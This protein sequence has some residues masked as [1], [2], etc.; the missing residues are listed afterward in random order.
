MGGMDQERVWSEFKNGSKQAFESV[1]NYCI[2][3][4]YAYGLKLNSNKE[5]VK[6]CIQQVFVDIYERRQVLSNPQNIK[7]YVLKALKHQ[8]YKRQKKEKKKSNIDEFSELKFKT[9]YNFEDKKIISE[10]D[11]KKQRLIK[12][13]LGSLSSKQREIMYLRFTTG[14]EY[15]EIAEMVGIDHNSVRKQVYRSIKKLRN[16]EIF[17]DYK[18]IILFY[19]ALSIA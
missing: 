17:D 14:M 19:S 12:K 9:P 13:A 18:S 8:I 11:E 16:S 7:Y 1:Y 5:L 2:D 3:D 10:I 6:D 4:M 15:T